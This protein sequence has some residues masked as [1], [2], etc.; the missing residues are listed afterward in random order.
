ML[1][2][3]TV[4]AHELGAVIKHRRRH[5]VERTGS[6]PTHHHIQLDIGHLNRRAANEGAFAQL[7]LN[8]KAPGRELV[9]RQRFTGRTLLVRV[10]IR[11]TGAIA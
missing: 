2:N 8:L 5:M 10:G 4:Q 3:G 6:Q 1:G 7:M 9:C 11:S